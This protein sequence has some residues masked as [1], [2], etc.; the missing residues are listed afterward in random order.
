M[1]TIVEKSVDTL[2]GD[3]KP[4]IASHFTGWVRPDICQR[5]EIPL[6][7]PEETEQ[8]GDMQLSQETDSDGSKIRPKGWSDAKWRSFNSLRKNPN[9]YFYRH[10]EPNVEQW[11]GDWIEEEKFLFLKIARKYGIGDKWGLFSTYIPHRVGYQ[12]ASFYRQVILPEGLVIDKN[13]KITPDGRA[14]Y[15]GH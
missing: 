2:E 7:D 5:Y 9:A 8:E 1:E 3:R 6:R 14:I 10:N 15:V 13:Y 4:M 11:C 12:C